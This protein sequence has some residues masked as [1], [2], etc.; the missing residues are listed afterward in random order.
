MHPPPSLPGCAFS[1]ASI[2]VYRCAHLHASFRR[3]LPLQFPS[4]TVSYTSNFVLQPDMLLYSLHVAL[5]LRTWRPSVRLSD[6]GCNIS[7]LWSHHHHRQVSSSG[8]EGWHAAVQALQ[9][10]R[11]CAKF[12]ISSDVF[13]C[14]H[15]LILSS[16]IRLGLPCAVFASS[17]P[18]RIFNTRSSQNMSCKSH[19]LF[20]NTFIHTYF[21][22]LYT[23]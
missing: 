5:M 14:V 4:R 17:L 1:E 8:S 21:I 9:G 3:Q 22:F 13:S 20:L 12:L 2:L 7:G 11:S 10:C 6:Y 19:F 18:S 16:H 23:S 15:S